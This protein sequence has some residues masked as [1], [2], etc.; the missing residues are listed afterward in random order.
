VRVLV[1][2][3]RSGVVRRA[4][5]ERG[6]DAWS[7]DLEAADDGSPFHIQGDAILAAYR[8]RYSHREVLADKPFDEYRAWDLLIAHPECTYLANSGAKHLYAG[9]KAENGPNGDRWAKMGAA[10]LFFK[11][12]L[13][14][15]IA[16]IAVENPIMLGHP[17][18]IFGIPEPTQIIQPWQ[19]GHGE[20]KATCL[21]LKGLPPLQPTNIVEGRE[22]RIWRMGPGPD[23]KRARSETF[24]GIAQAMAE[25]WSSASVDT[26]A[27]RRD[28]EQARPARVGSAVLSDS[29]ADAQT[30]AA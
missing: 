2:C 29:E 6:H 9:M 20:T 22:Q 16:R 11:Q 8:G 15:P 25:Q 4:F 18:R 12:L 7:C 5:R 28:V 26:H 23:R 13:D 27:E 1:A 14:A 19:F 3:E 30:R 10:A 24:A 17:R 21:W